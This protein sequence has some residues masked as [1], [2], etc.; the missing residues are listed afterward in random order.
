[1]IIGEAAAR[2]SL[3]GREPRT[4]GDCI[5]GSHNASWKFP[6]MQTKTLQSNSPGAPETTVIVRI[7]RPVKEF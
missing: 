2:A 3:V 6:I 4:P 5:R 1:M 7:A